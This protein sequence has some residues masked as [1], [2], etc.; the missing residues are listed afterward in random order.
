MIYRCTNAYYFSYINKIGGIE[1]HLYY[2]ARKYGKYDIC[3][4]YQNGDPKQIERLRSKV[5][6]VKIDMRDRVEC[7][8]L[9]CCFNREI[10]DICTAET[11]Y[12]VLHGDYYA[13]LQ[14]GQLAKYQL[15]ID[16][17]IDKYLGVSQLVCDSWFKA[18]G[19]HAE[20]IGEPVVL[21][22]AKKPL[23]FCSATRLS[24]EK[25][26]WRMQKL[27]EELDRKGL[28]YLWM[29]Y[30][31]T[32][33]KPTENMI[34]C[35]PRLD[36]TD[37]LGIY[38]AFIQLSDNEGFCLSVV[39]ALMRR[40]P[41]ICTDLPV[42]NELGL[43]DLNSIRLPLD[44]RNI[45]FER[46]EHIDKMKFYYEAP[47]DRW[48]EVLDHTKA[49]YDD[50]YKVRATKGWMAHKL[51]DAQ[52]GKI[53]NEGDTWI[54]DGQRLETLTEYEKRTGIKLVEIM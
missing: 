44:M 22:K 26:W 27:A 3:V 19:I 48:D 30:T 41:V 39:E 7:K 47:K 1:S 21:D 31:D 53:P 35:Q 46:I 12:L 6:A 23:L 16:P 32:Q 28:N 11:K 49:K 45:P 42:F 5:K 40:V 24:K 8:N 37:K 51:T 38:D 20:F 25:G 18:T 33:Q 43:N 17:R 50:K 2:I 54:I 4:Y 13:M 29:I 52:Q 14:Q 10:L 34:F 15:P 9:F 36:I